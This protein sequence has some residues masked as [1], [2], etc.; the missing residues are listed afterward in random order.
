MV[1]TMRQMEDCLRAKEAGAN[2]WWHSRV[3]AV[4][5]AGPWRESVAGMN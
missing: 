4:Q 1:E 2:G 3:S 5:M